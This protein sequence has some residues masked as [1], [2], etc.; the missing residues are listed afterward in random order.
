M[1]FTKQCLRS[2]RQ[3]F[4]KSRNT[5]KTGKSKKIKTNIF[6]ENE[7]QTVVPRFN[8]EKHFLAFKNCVQFKSF[9]KLFLYK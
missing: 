4:N 7:I 1:V 3:N 6:K 8:V 9:E 2:F 5:M